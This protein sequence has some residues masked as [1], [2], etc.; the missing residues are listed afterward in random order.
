LH[1]R[2]KG[3]LPSF[4]G[5]GVTLDW[6]R[7][8]TRKRRKG[9][10]KRYEGKGKKRKGEKI[11]QDFLESTEKGGAKEWSTTPRMKIKSFKP[12]GKR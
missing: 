8:A 6:P 5:N 12:S 1:E 11:R 3:S 9:G 2:G 4:D 7:P 10:R